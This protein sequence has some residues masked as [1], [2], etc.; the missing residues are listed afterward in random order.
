MM[1]AIY[2]VADAFFEDERDR[3]WDEVRSILGNHYTTY[4]LGR[5]RG[6]SRGAGNSTRLAK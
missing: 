4:L 5:G 1:M 3:N 2:H 6:R